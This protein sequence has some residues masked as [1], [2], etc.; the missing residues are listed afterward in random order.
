M[1]TAS[2]IISLT[3]GGQALPVSEATVT[4]SKTSSGE[5]VFTDTV[6]TDISGRTT[7][8]LVPT[9]DRALSLDPDYTGIPYETYDVQVEVFGYVG[10]RVSG[11]QAF[12]EIESVVPIELLPNRTGGYDGPVQD[13][14][15]PTHQLVAGSCCEQQDRPEDGES[16]PWI[17][18]A[19][20]IPRTITVHL[21]RPNNTSAQNY[22][23][24]FTEYI[25]NVCCSEIYPTWPESALRANIYCQISLALNRVY[26]EWYRSRGYDFDITNSTQYDQAFTKG[27]EIATNV[28]RIVDEIFNQYV[29]KGDGIEP[30]YTEYC[31]GRQVTCPGLKQWGTVS[32]ANQGYTPLGILRHYYGSSVYLYETDR[33]E[34]IES[35][36]PGTPLRRGSS[37][38]PVAVIQTQ[39]N[40]IRRN[41]PAIPLISGADGVFGAQT[42]AAVR[43]FQNIF[44]LSADGVVGKSTWYKISYI[45][46]AV[47]KLA[48]LGSE[49]ADI[50]QETPTSVLQPGSTGGGVRYVQYML[51]VVSAFYGAVSAPFPDGVYG[52]ATQASV[53]EFQRY[54]GLTPDGRVGTV[55]YNKLLEVFSQVYPLIQ[56]DCPCQAYG[57][58]VLRRGSS[59]NA[60]SNLQYY[61]NAIGFTSTTIPQLT[62]DGVFGA[63]TQRAVLEFQRLYSLTADG[64]VGP[65]TWAAICGAFCSLPVKPPCP[66]YGGTP[67]RVGSTGNSVR[68]LQS[69]LNVVSLQYPQITRVKVDGIFGTATQ[70]AVRTFQRAVGI[71]ADGVA[72]SV[73]WANLCRVYSNL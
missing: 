60:V 49:G 12:D 58:T 70:T 61:L 34:D 31:D 7:A 16:G 48:E 71:T 29:R 41:Y 53:I 13:F 69:I 23:L 17:L 45:Y 67:L 36:Y 1:S 8:I 62:V 52:P 4:L 57:G 59:G 26:T 33:I 55:T 27:R 39:L 3:V 65:I 9:V 47:T 14:L 15:V 6:D 37:G 63:A 19:P 18:N 42:E 21:G 30:Y 35:S 2:F 50:P 66:G 51:S 10:A 38:N 40:R 56:N 11:I 24:S 28:S 46:T 68:N 5:V 72:G 20:I 73:T 54:F 22:R 44:D 25:K 32:L 64:L 43:A